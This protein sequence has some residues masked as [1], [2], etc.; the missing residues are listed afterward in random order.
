MGQKEKGKEKSPK[1]APKRTL[2]EK[3]KAKQE[4]RGGK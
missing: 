1:T 2:M 3:R 4:K